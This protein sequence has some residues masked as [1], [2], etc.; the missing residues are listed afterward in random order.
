MTLPDEGRGEV[1]PVPVLPRGAGES[2]GGMQ[3][4]NR[5][6]VHQD[7]SEEETE[8]E[9]DGAEVG[10]NEQQDLTDEEEESEDEEEEEDQD[11]DEESEQ[12]LASASWDN[13][14]TSQTTPRIKNSRSCFPRRCLF[15]LSILFL[16]RGI[17]ESSKSTFLVPRRTRSDLPTP[18]LIISYSPRCSLFD[19]DTLHDLSL[20]F[21]PLLT[22]PLTF[23]RTPHQPFSFLDSLFLS[24]Y[25]SLETTTS[26]TVSTELPE[27]LEQFPVGYE[28]ERFVGIGLG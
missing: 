25:E 10:W 6:V 22:D 14:A 13:P 4:R 27:Q 17:L 19:P 7:D 16:C 28:R 24:L 23:R 26:D 1:W 3:T 12:D 5:R 11:E 18:S 2:V 9:E 21:Q 8:N 15:T 20:L